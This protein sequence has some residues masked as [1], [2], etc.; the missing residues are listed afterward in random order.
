MMAVFDT[1][2]VASFRDR[3]ILELLY[4]TGMRISEAVGLE[5]QN[6]DLEEAL[7]RVEGKRNKVRLIPLPDGTVEWLTR[8][9]SDVRPKLHR[10]NGALATS[11]LLLTDRGKPMLRQNAFKTVQEAATKAGLKKLPSP[12]T[13]R[14]TYAVHLLRGGADLRA[15][16]ELLG[17]ESLETTQIYTQLQIDEIR[18]HYLKAHPR[19]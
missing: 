19:K 4:G 9:L 6:I 12:H 2:S 10:I 3:V 18:A 13:I 14:H 17:H 11:L 1:S 15:V 8:Y 5:L 7:V 16:Q